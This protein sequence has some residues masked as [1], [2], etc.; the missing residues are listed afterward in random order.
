MKTADQLARC[1][2]ARRENAGFRPH[3]RHG[4]PIKVKLDMA[5]YAIDSLLH[6]KFGSYLRSGRWALKSQKIKI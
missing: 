3:G 6:A 1:E 5:Q 2:N 4:V